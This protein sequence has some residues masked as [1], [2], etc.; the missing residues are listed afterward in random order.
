MPTEGATYVFNQTTVQMDPVTH[1]YPSLAWRRS[2][3]TQR[4]S[5]Y[6]GR[7]GTKL[8]A[9]VTAKAGATGARPTVVLPHG[10]PEAR[11]TYGYDA[12]AQFLAAQRLC[13]RAAQLPR[14][15]RL[16]GRLRDRR[17]W[18]VGQANAG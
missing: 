14:I 4:S 13:G 16:W 8:W 18:S 11:D 3:T 9:Y 17:Q 7:D 5:G 12:F 2:I 1:L 15:G 6:D 10:G